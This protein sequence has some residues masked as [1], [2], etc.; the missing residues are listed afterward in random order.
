[1]E[2]V[3]IMAKISTNA[4]INSARLKEQASDPASPASNYAQVYVKSTGLFL[5]NSAGT[6]TG[7][8]GTGGAGVSDGDKGDIT[9]SASGATWTIDNTVVS[10][11]KLATVAT[12]TIKGRTTAGTG[13]PEDLT[14][15]QATAILNAVVGDSGSGGTKGL[16]PAP[17]AGDA[18]AAKFLKADGTWAVPAGGGGVSDGD[19]G[20]ITVTASGATWTIDNTVVSNA[21]L[22]TV[23]TATLK[24]RTTAGTGAPE[25]LTATQATAIL[26][27]VV[28]DSGSGG[29]KGLAPA[30]AAGDAAAAK[31]LKA[32]GTWAVPAGGGGGT[33]GG[34]TTQVQYNNA[35]AFGGVTGFTYISS[36]ATLAFAPSS[37]ASPGQL[38]LAAPASSSG[39][40]GA[41]AVLRGGAGPAGGSVII[42]GGAA[43][44]GASGDAV[45]EGGFGSTN[46]KVLLR[47]NATERLRITSAGGVSF[48]SSGTGYGSSGQVLTSNGDAPPSFQTAGGVS[49]GDKG[50]ITVT[51]SGA[52]WTID[53]TVV[54]NAKLATVA[55]A[56]LKGRT[57]AGTGAPEDLTATQATAILNAVVGDS[58]SGGTKGLAPAPAAGDA[59]AAK[60]LKA[61]GT[62]AVPAA[63]A[64]RARRT[65][66]QTVTTNVITQV[67]L[68]TEDFDTDSAF[69]NTTNYRFTPT[70]AGYYA[71][72]CAAYVTA[73]AVTDVTLYLYKNGSLYGVVY[74]PPRNAGAA[75]VAFG[76]TVFLNGSTDYI[77]MFA[78]V[79]GTGT[80]AI[81]GNVV[82]SVFSAR[83]VGA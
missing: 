1:L 22:A 78:R 68:A 47:T 49:D 19:K 32:D 63:S 2:K 25:D 73:T 82:A 76:D 21:K 74:A 23:A 29:T 27:A 20:D 38:T 69:D 8:F 62:W 26:N 80:C 59:A 28:G 16:A 36:S 37:V 48:G 12:A 17:A 4:E 33:P 54:S 58:G 6:V 56:T 39:S 9:V 79:V 81:A 11:A 55:T 45:L 7:P 83:W 40:P 14:A 13:A 3:R 67:Q 53:N 50:D 61:D 44:S 57:T 60:F 42:T 70:R 43:A 35:G 46:G 64:F 31:F 71:A 5:K 77:E 34:S 24:G 30:P 18:A 72:D 52:T 66:S 65:T 15:T 10:N 41:D 51:A 75:S